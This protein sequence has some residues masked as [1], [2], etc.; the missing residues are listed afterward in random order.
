[1]EFLYLDEN[2]MI[3]AGVTD[4]DRCVQAMEDMLFLLDKGDYRMSGPNNNDHGARVKFPKESDIEGMPLDAPDRWFTT[5]PAYLGG[6]FHSFGIKSYGSNHENSKKDLPRSILMMQLLDIDTGAPVAYMSANIMSAMRTGA[7][8]G[9]GAKY[10]VDDDAERVAIIGPGVMSKYALDAIMTVKPNLKH[11]SV[12]GRGKKSMDV[13]KKW[14][15][16]YS[17]ESFTV[18]STVEEVC[19]DADVIFTGNTRA[20]TFEANPYISD[21]YLKDGA[22]II[23]SSAVRY[24]RDF[25]FDSDRCCCYADFDQIY[26]PGYGVDAKPATKETENQVT[27]NN[28]LHDMLVNNMPITNIIE[29]IKNK[30]FKKDEHKIHIY[31]AYGMPVEDVAWGYDCYQNAMKLGIGTKLKL[32]D[33]PQI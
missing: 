11:I 10:L 24:D 28:A 29:V 2:Q 25:L 23:A 9:V 3:E 17:F 31:G 15:E 21:S 13:F 27:Y 12:L 1:M 30:G 33:T 18:C 5:M 22:V 8:G 14:C 7:I 6:R 32:W 20:E 19:K 16:K 4:M 26:E